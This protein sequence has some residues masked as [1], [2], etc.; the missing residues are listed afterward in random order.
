MQQRAYLND[1]PGNRPAKLT[2]KQLAA[3]EKWAKMTRDERVALV[4]ESRAAGV[5]MID[6]AW[7]LGIDVANLYRVAP[8]GEVAKPERKPASR[9]PAT[10]SKTR[11]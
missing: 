2:R 10:T 7:E 6:L 4:T 8:K 5:S 11:S 3:K 9:K 1:R